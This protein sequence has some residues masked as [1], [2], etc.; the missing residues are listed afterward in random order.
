MDEAVVNAELGV[1]E[2]VVNSCWEGLPETVQRKG[3]M[4]LL[5]T[6]G[7][8]LVGTL[9]QASK[10][11]ADY[12]GEAWA[13]DAATILLHGKRAAAAGAAFANGCSANGVDID[14]CG[15]YTR[16]HPG[17]QVLAAALAM[18]EKLD[19]SGAQMLTGMVVGYEVALRCARCWHDY[20]RTYHAC[21][22]WGSVACAAIAGNMMHLTLGQV[23]NALGIAEYHAPNLPMMR[24]ID[25]PAMVKHG[26]GW[27]AMTGILS[28]DLAARGFTGIPS[29]LSLEKYRD[30]VSDIGKRYAMVDGVAWK[31]HAGCAWGH[32]ALNGARALVKQ[33]SIP[34]D[35][36]VHIRVEAFHEAVRLGV[37][38]PS[39]T[40]EAQFSLA[41]PLAAL[42]IHG[43]VGP[44]QM[45]EPGLS[46][47]RVRDLAARV[48]LVESEE[49]D[50]LSRNYA[51]G[52]PQGKL[53]SA[54]T[55]SLRDGSLLE[56]GIV[57]SGISYPQPGWDEDRLEAK[58]RRLAGHVLD[59]A[60][61]DEL[62]DLVWHFDQVPSVR[63]LTSILA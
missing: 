15:L 47:Q 40:E 52:D 51:R 30:W 24:D 13:G 46:D 16:G 59:E 36:I 48:E 45:L 53:A 9:T 57:E 60:G 28:A 43:E 23:R 44:L 29:I 3:R 12:A 22:S 37:D 21:G 18:A 19:L 42:L 20:H 62:I 35:E 27:G 14:D 8:A 2:F 33:H 17:A 31:E 63:C 5:D 56:S 25:S 34:S 49:L 10:I 50:E 32:A 61:V 55:I 6:L 26:I 58:V 1:A 41:W 38:L 7:A 54:V 39:T 4:C 11:A